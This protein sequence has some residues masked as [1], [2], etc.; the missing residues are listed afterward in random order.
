MNGE[1]TIV[2]HNYAGGGGGGGEPL[3]AIPVGVEVSRYTSE[4]DYQNWMWGPSATD[5]A[6]EVDF[7]M[8]RTYVI[9]ELPNG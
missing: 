9:Y 5:G 8:G 2:I 1:P 6:P 3:E 7:K 4:G